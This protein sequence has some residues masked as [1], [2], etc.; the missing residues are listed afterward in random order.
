MQ[1][2]LKVS[3]LQTPLLLSC[4]AFFTSLIAGSSIMCAAE[5]SRAYLVLFKRSPL[6]ELI[7]ILHPLVPWSTTAWIHPGCIFAPS[8]AEQLSFAI[9]ALGETKVKFAMRG[10]GHM[11]IAS[12][13]SIGTDG[14]LISS[15][16]LSTLSLSTDNETLSVGPGPRWTDAYTLLEG[17]GRQVVGG[18]IGP[19]GI[20]GLL[21]GGGISFYSYEYG[22]A[23]T[24]GNVKAYQVQGTPVFSVSLFLS[25]S[26]LLMR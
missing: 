21:L 1:T 20:P 16:N 3:S 6:F 22:M 5:D 19:V 2:R 17:T 9:K 12:A 8:N 26:Y 25:L 18:R 14:V 24:N 10:G 15:T 11:P 23:S 13:N 4:L 7:S